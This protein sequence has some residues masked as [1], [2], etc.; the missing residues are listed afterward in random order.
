[1]LK[2]NFQLNS[3]TKDDCM[4]VL[5]ILGVVPAVF[6]QALTQVKKKQQKIHKQDVI[7]NDSVKWNVH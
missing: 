6:K 3:M 1:M 5:A 4:T 2:T 7:L